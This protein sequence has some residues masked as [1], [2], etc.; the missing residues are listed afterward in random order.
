MLEHA[1]QVFPPGNVGDRLELGRR[2]LFRFPLI[3]N[4]GNSLGQ[5]ERGKTAIDRQGDDGI[6][7]RDRLIGQASLFTTEH[8]GDTLARGDGRPHVRHGLTRRHDRFLH[9]PGTGRGG[10]DPVHIM[11]GVGEAVF[12]PG[13]V[14]H[15]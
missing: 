11:Q 6:G 13:I 3:G 12:D 2:A 14:M 1:L 15:R 10:V 8:D 9:S 5:I 7:H 4:H